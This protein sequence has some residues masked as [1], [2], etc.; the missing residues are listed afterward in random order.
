MWIAD[1]TLHFRLTET[2]R[3]LSQSTLVAIFVVAFTACA[4]PPDHHSRIPLSGARNFR[5]LGGY[6]ASDG[7]HIKKGLL[8]RSDDLSDLSRRDLE[9]LAALDLQRI[10]D[11]RSE[12]ERETNLDR[13]PD[14]SSLQV[15]ELPMSYEPLDPEIMRELILNGKLEKGDAQRL[16]IQAYRTYALDYRDELSELLQG[17]S[18]PSDLP[19]LIHCTHG[20]DRTGVAVAITLRA[21]DV[22]QET[23]LEDYMLSNKF[24][25]SKTSHLSC[26]ASCASLFR[27]PRSEV[28]ALLEVRPEYLE[29]AFTAI[30]ERYGSFDNYLNEGLSIDKATLERL[31][32]SL[33]E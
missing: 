1:C 8:Y 32:A 14:V 6:A 5:D 21:L 30:D 17:L 23:V 28:N 33:L 11:L 19:A 16:M 20:R 24:W 18:D 26:L 3:I 2:Y 31:K 25:E 22:P 27:T 15:V 10:Y 9:A 7:H 12:L 4:S 29:A 13:L